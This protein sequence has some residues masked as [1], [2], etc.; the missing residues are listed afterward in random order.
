MRLVTLLR[1]GTE[2]VGWID[3]NG[4]QIKLIDQGPEGPISSL[5]DI[6]HG[7]RAT[8]DYISDNALNLEVVA[9]ANVELLPPLPAVQGVFCVGLNYSE[10]E[11]EAPVSGSDFPTV[12]LRLAR[13]QVSHLAPLVIPRVSPTLDWEGELV[14]V[15]GETGRHIQPEDAFDH[16]FGYSIYNEASVRGYQHH[17][18]QF[19]MGKNFEGTGAFGPWIQTACSFGDPYE[20][21][22]ET[23]IDGEL[24]QRASVSAMIHKIEDVIAYLS[25]ATTLYAGDIICTGTPSGV[26]AAQTPQRFLK[27]GDTVSVSVSDLGSLVNP[28]VEEGNYTTFE[29]RA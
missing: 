26:G 24:V 12:F 11:K 10:H 13:N 27:P 4:P 19:G 5:L 14:V 28:V 22:L 1:D 3:T 15:I 8:L 21:T 20:K 9:Q 2:K 23:R 17:T 6:I 29:K 16:I 25:A 18:S 7:G